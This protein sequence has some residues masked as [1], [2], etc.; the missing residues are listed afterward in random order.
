MRR[1]SVHAVSKTTIVLA[2]TLMAV[3]SV[4]AS[5]VKP[6]GGGVYLNADGNCANPPTSSRTVSVSTQNPY[7]VIDHG[8]SGM[9][10]SHEIWQ[11]VDL[12]TGSVQ[13]FGTGDG[14]GNGLSY[15]CTTAPGPVNLYSL[16]RDT[17]N[18]GGAMTGSALTAGT[19]YG[20]N[21]TDASNNTSVTINFRA[22]K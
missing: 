7:L 21:V 22:T 5:A 4:D 6:G 8:T 10:E 11:I 17:S 1:F 15:V 13:F 9:T 3:S 14:A 16:V 20:L 18:G 2:A 19:R 12:H